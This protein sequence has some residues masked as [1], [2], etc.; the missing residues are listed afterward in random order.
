MRAAAD[1]RR[2]G[3]SIAGKL[4]ALVLAA[5]VAA[6]A[7]VGGLSLWTELSRYAD[8]KRDALT[9]T[10]RVFS[11]V[12]SRA[13]ASGDRQGANTVL[14][15]VAQMPDIAYARVEDANGAVFAEIGSGLRLG[16]D[17][18]I[19]GDAGD[20]GIGA[21]LA[22]RTI[23]TSTPIVQAG[24]EV[25]RFV[26]IARAAD[27]KDRVAAILFRSF[28][29]CVIALAI[30]LFIASRLQKAITGPI[31][32]LDAAVARIRE[33][34]TFDAPVEAT[35]NDE[36]GRLVEGFNAM[37]GEIRA[38][39]GRIEA[40]LKGLEREVDARTR[41]L[42]I[43]R[44]AA[45]QANR[46]KSDFLATMSHEIR[47]PMNGV[48]VMAELLAGA[49]LADKPRRYADVIV[50]SGKNL[51]A[52]INDLLDFSKIEAG[53]LELEN[54]R[55]D[56]AE[57][58]DQ[59]A[60]LFWERA[61]GKG[62][63]FAAYVAPDTPRFVMGDPVRIGQIVTNLVTNALKFTEA[64]HVLVTVTSDPRRPGVIRFAVRDTGIGIAKEKLAGVFTA[65]TQADQT[66]TRKFGGTG[67]GL[68]I[69]RRLAQAMGGDIGVASDVGK[70][71]T[72]AAHLPL[73]AAADNAPWP[74]FTEPRTAV[75]DCALPAT[76][77][78]LTQYLRAA[79][80]EIAPEGDATCAANLLIADPDRFRHHPRRQ[81]AQ[82]I[83]LRALGDSAADQVLE[84]HEADA[85]LDL[86]LLRA[87]VEALL[88]DLV[89]GSVRRRAVRA[90]QSANLPRYGGRTVLVVD[91]NAVNRE[92]AIESLSRFHVG[93]ETAENGRIAVEMAKARLY[94]LILMDGS[95][96]EMD[97]F[98]STRAIRAHEAET[99]APRTPVVAFTADVL[100][101]AADAW[102][103]AG[104]DGV[105]HK[106]FTIAALGA[107]LATHFGAPDEAE[108]DLAPEAPAEM[109]AAAT[110]GAPE[111]PFAHLDELGAT[112]FVQ[113]V[114]GLYLD[115]APKR[116][117]ELLAAV[118]VNNQDAAARAAHAIKSMSL[119]LGATDVAQI[120]AA[121]ERRV[122]VDNGAIDE[123][124]VAAIADAIET[125]VAILAR[126]IGQEEKLAPLALGRI[127]VAGELEAAIRT[128]QLAL[129]YQ[130]IF[131][132][133]GQR[134]L[135]FE[136]LVR[137]TRPNGAAIS[138]PDMVRVAEDS[139]LIALLGDWAIDRAA[140][141][142]RDWQGVF[143]TVNASPTQ[144]NDHN[145]DARVFETLRKRGMD[146]KRFVIEITEQATLE[147]EQEVIDL[148]KRLRAGGVQIALDDFGTGFSSL[149]HL[150][151]F[152]I[153]K[154]KIDKSFVTD[155]GAG[156]EG[157]T[158]IHAV[159]A[160]G[161]T[162][163]FQMVA[164]GV[165]TPE[166]HAFLRAAGVHALQGWLFGKAMPPSD[167][168]ALVVRHAAGVA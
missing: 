81:G 80:Y 28:L 29:A 5:V 59:T 68:T 13:V 117:G 65:F 165:E 9:S 64:G 41:D 94:D 3:P 129:H 133:S 137:W 51:L 109:D 166:Q 88:E 69:C 161:R 71:S 78:V 89:A 55:V 167:A 108:E 96:P 60:S 86:P 27:L 139:G 146:P 118:R 44:D 136:G 1:I 103:T 79:G 135:G 34:Q 97:G 92:V 45:E 114:V 145:F 40:H 111:D 152:P 49:K 30:G 162:L 52:I 143:V 98:Q 130:P 36:V 10:A 106:P 20:L 54:T 91:D 66:T 33:S 95:M 138:P 168:A 134:L 56:L 39:D 132:R 15:G 93:A 48:L 24:E 7:T 101:A 21:L 102:E 154:V 35:S 43:A 74:M 151:R 127:G 158:I 115:Q 8:A 147:A 53:K 121:A 124:D 42:R 67:L 156:L 19:E 76:R 149:T 123:V 37:L 160:I 100:G 61:R 85:A 4:Q 58:V 113:R 131:D 90:P 25:G 141:D 105:L 125:T 17:V 32:R 6:T 142:A 159:V 155:L 122:R 23:E 77:R 107:H 26:L 83:V 112:E 70:G 84:E 75:V 128:D 72:F 120:C 31:A 144:L 104:A 11:S 82:R 157:A 116:F 46:A 14:R 18:R 38:R 163:G 148:I 12:V 110:E 99:G 119:S 87:D 153:D 2:N 150:R 140:R 16:S 73:P 126:K 57:I 164:E 50:R 62:L 22:T 47:T 63:D